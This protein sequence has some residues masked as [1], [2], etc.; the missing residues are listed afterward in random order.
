MSLGERLRIARQSVG[1]TLE[2][3]AE[4][5]G[6][7]VS[8]LSEFE[9][10]KRE[11]R[12][13]QLS[14]LG[15]IYLRSV[16]YFL[17]DSP[18]HQDVVLWRSKPPES[19]ARI[20]SSRFRELCERFH[21]LEVWCEEESNH[22]LPSVPG[23]PEH[24]GYPH[25][26][27]LASHFRKELELG[28]RPGCELLRVLE[29][30]CHV[31][32]FHL[33]FQPTGAAAS[34]ISPTFGAAILLN[35]LNSRWRRNFD[36]AHELFHLLTW[37]LFRVSSKDAG[38]DSASEHEEK[39]ATCFARNLLMPREAVLEALSGQNLDGGIPPGAVG[40]LARQFDVSMEAVLWHLQLVLGRSEAETKTDI[41]A[42]KTA[43]RS[44]EERTDDRPSKLPRR[45]EALALRAFLES[46]MSIGRYAEYVG[47]SRQ[48]AAKLLEDDSNG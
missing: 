43:S 6:L 3:V 35:A 5:S 19:E 30:V 21:N 20:V 44:Y 1:L 16:G 45:F 17:S 13:S 9:T 42:L 15:R 36:L 8:S 24:L 18:V 40:A 41:Q 47:V 11:P 25:A 26:E 2:Q 34:T 27:A 33:E 7:G 29:E 4:K 48:Q 14:I 46:R 38:Q 10:A 31:K 23:T 32:V 39:L 12:L 37:N 28:A 22:R